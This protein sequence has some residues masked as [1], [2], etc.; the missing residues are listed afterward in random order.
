MNAAAGATRV[1][2]PLLACICLALAIR[3]AAGDPLPGGDLIGASGF[4][5]PTAAAGGS[6]YLW[7][8]LGPDCDREPY[9]LL[10]NYAVPGVRATAQQQLATMRARGMQRLSLG[11]QFAHGSGTGTVIDSAD[12]AAVA[13]TARNLADLL[14]DVRAAGHAEVLFRFFPQGTINPSSDAFDSGLV[15]EYWNLVVALRPAL[16]ASGIAYRIDLFAEGM[17]RDRSGPWPPGTPDD[18]QWSRAARRLWQNYTASY[19]KLDT[20][21]FSFLTDDDPD[22]LNLRVRHMDQVYAGDYPYLVAADFYADGAISESDKFL[23]FRAAMREYGF[24]Q[25][26]WIISEGYHD[27]PS[28][29]ANFSAAIASTRQFVH[30]FTQ[31]PLD[32]ADLECNADVNVPPPYVWDVYGGYGF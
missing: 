6:N 27:D 9:G 2:G 31:W 30:Y 32:R 24:G 11:V 5:L 15:G 8:A 3:A 21:G 25:L 1:R 16:A 13:A 7:Y 20:V 10:A 29:A 23:T 4:D 18:P 17:P 12:A 26:G 28:A 22:K 14:A 19:G